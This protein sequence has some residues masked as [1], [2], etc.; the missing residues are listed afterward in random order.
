L[1]TSRPRDRGRRDDPGLGTLGKLL[2]EL[3]ESR[4]SEVEARLERIEQEMGL[5]PVER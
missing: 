1:T 2:G 5:K 3:L 4:D